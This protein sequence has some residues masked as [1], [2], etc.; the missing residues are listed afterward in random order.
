MGSYLTKLNV[1]QTVPISTTSVTHFK[2]ERPA[3]KLL[4]LGLD[5]AGKT[6][7]ALHLI[8][9]PLEDIIPTIGFSNLE[10]R[11]YGKYR[12]VVYDLGGGVRIRGIWKNY[13]ALV[14]GI[15]FV[16]DSSDISRI[17]EVKDVIEEVVSNDKISG[18]PILVLI[19]KQDLEGALE[20]L[21]ICQ[22]LKLESLINKFKC[23]TKVET[24]S[25]NSRPENGPK[26]DPSI[27]S[28][29]KWLLSFV[30]KNWDQLNQRVEN[31]SNEQYNQ[32]KKSLEDRVNRLRIKKFE[33]NEDNDD[34]LYESSD[35]ERQFFANGNPFKAI[36][37][38]VK[39]VDKQNKPDLSDD[40]RNR[41][42]MNTNPLNI[43][44]NHNKT[45]SDIK[46]LNGDK[47]NLP[48]Y[49]SSPSDESTSTGGYTSNDATTDSNDILTNSR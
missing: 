7:T 14:H 26:T 21:D 37:D 1:C 4:L 41:L 47:D 46:V 44:L 38:V 33:A 11:R 35:N 8:G 40:N 20:E 32:E 49:G 39:D 15:I 17:Y 36:K 27:D 48:K 24:C 10:L 5:N 22:Y 3:I 9:D 45:N 23:P 2:S 16:I 13:F 6:T 28:G 25:A 12:V 19:N 34:E 30:A 42:L 43:N 31:D 18:K 29:Y